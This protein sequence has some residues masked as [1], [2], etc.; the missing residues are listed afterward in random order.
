MSDPLD[1]RKIRI[2]LS[3][4]E[5]VALRCMLRVGKMFTQPAEAALVQGA[6]ARIKDSMVALGISQKII[7]RIVKL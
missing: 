2:A 7:D 5:L 6:L 3:V 1:L 4:R